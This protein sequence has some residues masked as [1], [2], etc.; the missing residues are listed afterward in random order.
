MPAPSRCTVCAL[1]AVGEVDGRLLAGDDLT[2]LARAYGITRGSLR[3]HRSAHLIV[4]EPPPVSVAA[5]PPTPSPPTPESP[6]FPPPEVIADLDALPALRL[7]E[8]DG[9]PGA[10]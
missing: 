3:R 4:P 7:T 5:Q 9:I 10:L 6:E 1:A 2:N 8:E